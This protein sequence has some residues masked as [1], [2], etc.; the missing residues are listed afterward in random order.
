MM[1]SL[2]SRLYAWTLAKSA[3]PHAR[4]WLA[5]LSASESIFFP[6]PPDVMLAPMTL[7]RPPDWWRLALITTGASVLGGLVGYALG[8]SVQDWVMPWVD[9]MGQREAF[10]TAVG[11]FEAYGFW[12]VLL[13][14]VTPIPYKVFTISAGVVHMGLLPFVLGSMA[15]R[16]LRFFLVAGL[17]RLVGPAVERHLIRYIDAI[18][19]L[20]VFLL[21]VVI[22]WMR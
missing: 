16:G 12:A 18:G 21:V 19:W 8:Y 14:G 11:W 1:G 4:R 15:G 3:H 20:L 6:I 2:F 7:A 22:I 17:V 5:G 10:D 9:R 13:A